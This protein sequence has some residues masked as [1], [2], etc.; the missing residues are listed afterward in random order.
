MKE[1]LFK[2]FNNKR[3]QFFTK[4]PQ[5]LKS[6]AIVS[7]K[8]SHLLSKKRKPFNNGVLVNEGILEAV[9]AIFTEFINKKKIFSVLSAHIVSRRIEV[10]IL[11][12]II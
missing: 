1:I 11:L 8:I 2:T 9:S 4:P 6:I 12:K 5:L 10:I 3:T 7:Y